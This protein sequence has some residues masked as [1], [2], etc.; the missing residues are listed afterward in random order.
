MGLLPK[1]TCNGTAYNTLARIAACLQDLGTNVK[2]Q[3]VLNRNNEPDVQ[4]GAGKEPVLEADREPVL[5]AHKE[6]S[7]QTAADKEAVLE[8][9]RQPALQTPAD[10]EPVLEAN[11]E[12]ALQTAAD[13]EPVLEAHKEPVLLAAADK[14]P[15]SNAVQGRYISQLC[16]SQ[17]FQETTVYTVKHVI[18]T[19]RSS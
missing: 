1:C 6:P 3:P 19:N 17:T 7:L 2:D 13:K 18:N 14:E 11:R 10:K 5:E 15:G 8:A 12:P 9:H 16:I 4:V